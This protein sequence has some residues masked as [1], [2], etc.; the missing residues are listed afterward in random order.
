[1]SG[2]KLDPET[3]LPSLDK[4]TLSAHRLLIYLVG[5]SGML[6]DRCEA[7]SETHFSSEGKIMWPVFRKKN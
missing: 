2:S 6:T 5:T 3:R 4:L 1:M 7:I